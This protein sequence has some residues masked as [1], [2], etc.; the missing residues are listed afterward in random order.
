MG[1]AQQASCAQHYGL[2][3]YCSLPQL[4]MRQQ[5]AGLVLLDST[6]LQAASCLQNLLLWLRL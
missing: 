1:R 3:C 5:S 6:A 4:Q 2:L